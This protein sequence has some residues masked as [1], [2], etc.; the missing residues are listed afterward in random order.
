MDPV[1]R[2]HTVPVRSKNSTGTND[3][4][5]KRAEI[6]QNAA[7]AIIRVLLA[8]FAGVEM[9]EAARATPRKFSHKYP[10]SHTHTMTLYFPGRT[11]YRPVQCGIL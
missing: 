9:R 8:D 1:L 5:L 11:T 10:K 2:Y 3:G 7:D 6:D 4:S